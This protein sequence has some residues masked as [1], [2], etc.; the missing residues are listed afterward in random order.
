MIN[1][2]VQLVAGIAVLSMILTSLV[3]QATSYSGQQHREI[4]SLSQDDIEDL[5]NGRGWGLAK[6]AELNGLPGP[7]HV[8]ELKSELGLS[9]LQISAIQLVYEAMRQ[10]AKTLGQRYVDQERKL[11]RL[12]LDSSVTDV[13]L[14]E[15]IQVNAR[16][17]GELRFTHLRAHLE[18]HSILSAAQIDRYNH[19]RGYGSDN[20]C[21]NPP[22]G[23]DVGMWK[24]HNNCT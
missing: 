9:A 19:L 1:H 8:L 5:L 3:V 7:V 24:K 4:K 16:T 10:E 22:D 20:P 17:H 2:K 6:P 18:M 14:G 21:E 12:L 11:E 13:Q 15:Q 23:H